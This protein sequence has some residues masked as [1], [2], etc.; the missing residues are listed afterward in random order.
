[1]RASPAQSPILTDGPYSPTVSSAMWLHAG[2][3]QVSSACCKGCQPFHYTQVQAKRGEVL[4]G[5]SP[6]GRR[7]L[8]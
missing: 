3:L 6:L 5:D 8:N 2:S 7:D 1:M 4:W